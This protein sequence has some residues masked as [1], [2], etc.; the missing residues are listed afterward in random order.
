MKWHK[1]SGLSQEL[2]HRLFQTGDEEDCAVKGKE[3]RESDGKA[4]HSCNRDEEMKTWVA[5]Y[6]Q[7][8]YLH[9]K[10]EEQERFDYREAFRSSGIGG[11]KSQRLWLRL[12]KQAAV[13][14]L[15]AGAGALLYYTY[16][17]VSPFSTAD[18]LSENILPGNTPA[19]LVNEEGKVIQLKQA[20]YI[21]PTQ[22]PLVSV[23]V[24]AHRLSYHVS[25][26]SP[27]QPDITDSLLY[28]TLIVPRGAEYTLTLSDGTEIWLN[29][30]SRIT[31]P[32]RFK[33][34][35]R[36]VSIS[37]E[38]YFKVQPHEG[39]S[40]VV[41]TRHGNIRVLGTE[42]NVTDYP[43]DKQMTVTLVKGRIA[44]GREGTQQQV[45]LVPNQQLTVS[46]GDKSRLYAVDPIYDICWKDGQFLFQQMPLEELFKQ[47]ERW[48]D[49]EV[50]YE[51]ESLKQL[52]FTGELS[53][54]RYIR[55]FI[56]MIEK[57]AG[58]KVRSKG[59]RLFIGR[60]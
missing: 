10:I 6:R 47:L 54:Y 16:T 7:K 55:T 51:D 28:N 34:T 45:E 52:H 59:R 13:V 30:D 8:G 49:V 50:S 31:Y 24:G 22:S 38:A 11:G 19:L 48:Y 2:L 18:V 46:S 39:K 32:I 42:F 23:E 60:E 29:A 5:K 41:Q 56:D 37:G 14:A 12:C 27:T 21:Q 3:S 57:S 33:G 1:V 40:F 17:E 4:D 36:E 9:R 15:L 58:I 20:H 35:T 53:R 25:T 26:L 44:Y 43:G